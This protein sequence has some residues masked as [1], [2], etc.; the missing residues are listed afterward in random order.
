[1]T[2]ARIRL[3]F[4]LVL[5]LCCLAPQA[6]AQ[7][8]P[9]S[10]IASNRER[11][12]QIRRERTQLREELARIRSQVH[13]VSGELRNIEQQVTTSNDLIQELD[14]QLMALNA[15]VDESAQ[16]LRVTH[17]HLLH[18]KGVLQR[19]L[20][21][22]YKRGPLHTAQVLLTADS[23]GELLNRY[24]YL[25]LLARS[26]RAL[27]SEVSA[28]EQQA[29]VRDRNLRR[30]LIEMQTLRNE[31]AQEH[32]VMQG[33]QQER[34]RTLSTVQRRERTTNQ[35]YQ[36]ATQNEKRLETLIA[37]LEAK[38]KEAE[39]RRLAAAG[40]NKSSPAAGD[41]L[42][43]RDLGAL[44]WPVEGTVVYRFGRSVRPNGTAVRN[45]GIGIAAPAGTPVKAVD[46]G[47]VVMAGP[48]EGY[49]PTVIVSHGEGYYSL[50]LYLRDI[51]VRDGAE[52]K[53]GEIVGTVG[54]AGTPEGAHVEFQI[55]APGGPAV[56]PL[57]WLQKRGR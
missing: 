4:P 55:R 23:F 24:K 49:G 46:G 32:V 1:M 21:Q 8:N 42:S 22:I 26:D 38:R 31:R 45:N 30:N 37:T 51:S 40:S 5:A 57:S 6:R 3:L 12:E 29:T 27:M 17:N 9:G 53:R 36:E 56:D 35:R 34:Q 44:G 10:E 41:G 47:T 50:Y 28:L 11:L 13:D 33:L 15:D 19:R 20:R 52:V 48:F 18:R 14:A 2:R 25:Y 16:E 54:G 7:G 43:T 39:R